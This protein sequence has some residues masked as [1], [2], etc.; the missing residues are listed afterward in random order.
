M[1]KP[2]D[3]ST[4]FLFEKHLQDWLPLSS[5][6]SNGMVEVV[7]TD[8]STVTAVADKVLFV[9]DPT[10]WILHVELQASWEEDLDRRLQHYNGLLDYRYGVLVHTMVILLRR[11][12]DSP[13]LTG[14]YLR[15][16][17]GEAPYR[18]FGYE[19]VRIWDLHL[20][21]LLKGGLGL[22]PLA[23]LTDE[24]AHQLPLVIHTM[25]ERIQQDAPPAEAADLW[26]ATDVLLGLRYSRDVID[27]IM[28]GVG[29]MEESVTYQA[30][31]EKGV[32]KGRHQGQLE[33]SR[34]MLL[35]QGTDKLGSPDAQSLSTLEAITDVKK[36]QDLG[37]RLLHVSNWQELLENNNE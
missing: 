6:Q 12:A 29:K 27:Q 18:T 25:E 31:I 34:Q 16:F 1:S 37:K 8:V 3:A 10:P 20:E 26:T 5:R 32:E 19:V 9:H 17:P 33:A 11:H 36:L 24:A 14:T 22:L 28:R 4:K 30:I 13:R 2:Y 35:L 15:G 7:D 21:H 23:P